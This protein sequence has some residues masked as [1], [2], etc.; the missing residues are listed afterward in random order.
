MYESLEDELGDIIAKARRGQELEVEALCRK[1]GI[2]EEDW[3]RLE[4]YE[5]TPDAPVISHIAE[6]LELDGQ[7]LLTSAQ[8]NFFPQKPSGVAPQD[9]HVEMLVLG[10]SFLMNGYVVGCRRTGRA[11]CVDPG[12]DGAKVLAA[13]AQASLSIEQIVL[14]HG[15]HDH[16]GALAEVQEETQ[17]RV[18]ISAEDR[19]ML[20]DLGS[21]VDA[22]ISEGD[23]VVVGALT[24][25]VCATGGHTP[26][27]ISL[28]GHGIALVGDALFAGSLGGTRSRVHYD[29]Q[30]RAVAQ[31]LLALEE[32]TALYPG[33]GPAT[34]VG[35]ERLNNPFFRS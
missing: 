30:R 25:A 2:A 7:K 8:R 18:Y 22:T 29:N 15:H 24:F 16:I 35:E 21:R 1:T 26:G 23:R 33:H 34:T 17:A 10:S 27:G 6:A 20:G 3:Q 4:R 28:V 5:W 13:A 32:E 9:V 12:F 31:H 19:P 14:T 11:L